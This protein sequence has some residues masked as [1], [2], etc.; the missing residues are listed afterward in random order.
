MTNTNT[1]KAVALKRCAAALL[2]MLLW[3]L[4]ALSATISY[5]E[6]SWNSNTSSVDKTLRSRDMNAVP[7]SVNDWAGLTNGWWYVDS[8]VSYKTLNIMGNDVNLVLCDGAKITCTGGVRLKGS[9]KLTIYSQSSGDNEGK[10]VVTQEHYDDDAGIG[11]GKNEEDNGNTIGMGYLVI[12]GGDISATGGTNGA[13][14]GGGKNRGISGTVTIY[15]GKV[16]ALRGGNGQKRGAGIGG[17]WCG[18][19]G[20]AIYIYG[21]EV[22]AEGKG[23]GDQGGAGIGGGGGDY[24]DGGTIKIFGGTVKATSTPND[25]GAAIGGGSEHSFEKIEISGGTVIAESQKYMLLGT[26]VE[27]KGAAIGSGYDCS[28]GSGIINITGGVVMAKSASGAAIGGGRSGNG[29]QVN[30]SGGSVMAASEDGAGIG[31]GYK[32]NGGNVTISGGNVT[33]WST[34]YGAGIG[35]GNNGNGGTL[36]MTGGYVTASGGSIHINWFKDHNP[37]F[38]VWKTNASGKYS[39]A[40]DVLGWI[41]V[42][43]ATSGTFYGAGVGGG[44]KGAGG[45]VSVTGGTLHAMGG[46]TG[47]PGIGSGRKGGSQGSLNMGEN[48]VVFTS[49]DEKYT[50]YRSSDRQTRAHSDYNVYISDKYLPLSSYGNYTS[51]IN[52]FNG[53][54]KSVMFTWRSL[55]CGGQYNTLCLPFNL[56]TLQDTPLEGAHIYTVKSSK[57]ENKILTLELEEDKSNSIVAGKPYVAKW[58]RPNDYASKSE[59]YDQTTVIFDEVT[60]SNTAPTGTELANGTFKG[61]YDNTV[62]STLDNT[63]VVFKENCWATPAY[64]GYNTRSFTCNFTGKGTS[65]FGWEKGN[66]EQIL[67]SVNGTLATGSNI[68]YITHTWDKATGTLEE[69]ECICPEVEYITESKPNEWYALNQNKWYVV[70][71]WYVERKAIEVHDNTYLI[72]NDTR[73][74]TLTGGLKVEYGKELHIFGGRQSS[75]KLTITQS[76][77]LTA[78]LGAARGNSFGTVS[79]HGGNINVTGTNDAAGIGPGAGDEDVGGLD[80]HNPNEGNLYIYGGEV[81]ARGGKN[82]AGIGC[83]YASQKLD[84]D[85]YGGTVKAYGG[86]DAAGIGGAY[87]GYYDCRRG[88][89]TIYGGTVEATA[90]SG[91]VGRDAKKGSAIGAGYGVKDKDSGLAFGKSAVNLKVSAGDASNNI[92][93]VFTVGEREAACHWRN[94]AKIEPCQ[95]NDADAMSYNIVDDI[96]HHER[97]KYCGYDADQPHLYDATTHKCVCG[98]VESAQPETWTVSFYTA[99]DVTSTEYDEPYEFKVVKGEKLPIPS[100]DTPEGLI[101]MQWMLNPETAPADYEMRDSEFRADDIYVEGYE[102]WPSFDMKLYAR[103]RYDAKETW[104]WNAN[105]PSGDISATVNVELANGDKPGDMETTIT[106]YYYEADGDDPAY[107]MYMASVNYERLSDVTYKFYDWIVREALDELV[108]VDGE[109]NSDIINKNNNAQ[110]NTLKLKDRTLY[111]NNTWNTIVL[112]FNL[113]IAGSPLDGYGVE[114]RQL[115]Q[116]TYYPYTN[117][118]SMIFSEPVTQINAG[119]PYIIKWKETT[120]N[121]TDPTFTNVIIDNS[122]SNM[123][124]SNVDFIGSY[125]PVTLEADNRYLRFIGS[126]NKIYWP[127]ADVTLGSCRAYFVL[128][129][130]ESSAAKL[131]TIDFSADKD[132]TLS[133]SPR[134]LSPWDGQDAVTYDLKGRM[135]IKQQLPKGIYIVGD[136][137][138]VTK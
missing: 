118:I 8:D 135:I 85:I 94:Y 116:G 5:Y 55:L 76:Y 109:D 68:H 26:M 106:P 29:G 61:A 84:V 132:A 7:A 133:V 37:E 52:A 53:Q 110:V 81:T 70:D 65:K 124:T 92:E 12:H 47:A 137:K 101:F 32:G 22:T 28:Q 113:T 21:G 87:Y 125:R 48:M 72:L 121:L 123:S 131:L 18:G 45:T 83:S 114:V 50:N 88:E 11:C 57:I 104:T 96:S 91:C 90:G 59:N 80:Y 17:G 20:G 73:D 75:G 69:F 97:C 117:S 36:T 4:T 14:I 3:H 13:A 122:K 134:G 129:G 56:S 120:T 42:A 54:K 99:K 41:I 30:I 130:I 9:N 102:L 43:A 115:E 112:P 40:L 39:A 31:G 119:N 25:G 105:V 78:A 15:G 44:D 86:E 128:K 1:G 2:L 95:H 34:T 93:R 82:A 16:K 35:G 100:Y 77:E 79:I 126:G 136:K 111:R 108:L 33:A 74:L 62:L 6:C 60:I 38:S 98:R 49:N 19:Q 138:V 51:D 89:V 71:S 10:L 23:Y 103:Y 27:S 24:G 64:A 63:K 58:D 66:Y 107:T 46:N 127:S 67:F